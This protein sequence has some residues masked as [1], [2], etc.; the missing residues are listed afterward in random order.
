MNDILR[1]APSDVGGTVAFYKS[2][3]DT[4]N[5][6]S[7]WQ[8]LYKFANGIHYEVAELIDIPFVQKLQPIL[9]DLYNLNPKD[10]RTKKD[11]LFI[12]MGLR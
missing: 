4:E 1:N 9:E 5:I 6:Y 7:Q 3:T 8:E 10:F 2:M 11:F 12:P